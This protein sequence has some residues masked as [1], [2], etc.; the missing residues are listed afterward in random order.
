M[1]HEMRSGLHFRAMLGLS[2]YFIPYVMPGLLASCFSP[3]ISALFGILK[4]V[5]GYLLC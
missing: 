5:L 1:V 2:Y 4:Q 3:A